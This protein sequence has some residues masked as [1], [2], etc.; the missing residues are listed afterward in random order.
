VGPMGLS[1]V[2]H[3]TPAFQFELDALADAC[4]PMR[5]RLLQADNYLAPI[6]V[7]TS[8]VWCASAV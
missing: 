4:K 7:R 5:E 1:S 6:P 3:G 2:S 8:V